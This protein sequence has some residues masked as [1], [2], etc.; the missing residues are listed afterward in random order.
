MDFFSG[1]GFIFKK[2][3]L[4]KNLKTCVPCRLTGHREGVGVK[5]NILENIGFIVKIMLEMFFKYE[6]KKINPFDIFF[7]EA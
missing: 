7:Y 6:Y 2:I 3:E 4:P 1:Y 5:I